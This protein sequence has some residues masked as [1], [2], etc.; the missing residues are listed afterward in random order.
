[1]K[2]RVFLKGRSIHNNIRLVLDLLDY[3]YLIE[4]DG[5]ILFLTLSNT[6]LCFAL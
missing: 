3:N 6:I 5:F 2:S 1:M 4:D